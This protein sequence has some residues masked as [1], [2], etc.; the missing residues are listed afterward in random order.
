MRVAA[1]LLLL[2]AA[3]ACVIPPDQTAAT[4]TP[5][6]GPYGAA[7]A[8]APAA[9]PTGQLTCPQIFHCAAP[10]VD[11]AC[12][13]TCWDQGG[14]GDRE[15]ATAVSTCAAQSGCGTDQNC[16]QARCATQI[17]MCNAIPTATPP[18]PAPVAQPTRPNPPLA[19]RWGSSTANWNPAAGISQGSTKHEYD[20][21]ADGTYSFRHEVFTFANARQITEIGERGRWTATA[22]TLTLTPDATVGQLRA[23]DGGAVVST[24]EVPKETTTYRYQYHYLSGSDETVLVLTP[25][26]ATNRDGSFHGHPLF[27]AS[28]MYH[29]DSRFEWMLP[30]PQ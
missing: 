13:R 9:S 25:P 14:V 29:L 2:G 21:H 10:C 4:T 5:P 17:Q 18:A 8:P 15:R 11:E 12:T 23:K 20:L 3:S 27:P 7:P 16:I 28:Y 19:S 24:F 22:D 30:A 26:A 1:L 6:P